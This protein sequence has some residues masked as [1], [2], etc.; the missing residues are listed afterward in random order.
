M[1]INGILLVKLIFKVFESVLEVRFRQLPGYRK[2][3]QKKYALQ[4]KVTNKDVARSM[5]FNRSFL[6]GRHYDMSMIFDAARAQNSCPACSLHTE[7][8]SGERVKW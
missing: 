6:P 3:K 1:R 7:E 5:A 2:I 4:A 8:A